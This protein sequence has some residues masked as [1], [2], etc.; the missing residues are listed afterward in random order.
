LKTIGKK[1][2]REQMTGKTVLYYKIIEE[3][4]RGGDLS[5]RPREASLR[6]P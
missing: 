1:L 2:P 4:G 3:L 5:R 6:K